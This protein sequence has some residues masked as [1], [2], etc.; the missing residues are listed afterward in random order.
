MF[1]SPCQ[2]IR[3]RVDLYFSIAVNVSWVEDFYCFNE[4]VGDALTMLQ[5]SSTFRASIALTASPKEV[6]DNVTKVEFESNG[7]PMTSSIQFV[8]FNGTQYGVGSIG[9]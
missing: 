1:I 3:L 8:Y 9:E 7:Q 2:P 4:S 5:T 6:V